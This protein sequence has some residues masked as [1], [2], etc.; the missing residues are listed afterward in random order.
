MVLDFYF[1]CKSPFVQRHDVL[2]PQEM[3]HGEK[4]KRLSASSLEYFLET[5][6]L[7]SATGELLKKYDRDGD[8]SFSKE[9]VVEIIL[10]LRKEMDQNVLLGQT[11]KLLRKLIIATVIFCLVLMSSIFGLAYAVAKLTAK[12]DV[13]AVTG[14]MTT[15]DGSR[16][17]AT[18]S[19]AYKVSTKKHEAT[20]SQCISM[21]ELDDMLGR[22]TSGNIVHLEIKGTGTN[23]T[24]TIVEKLTGSVEYGEDSFC[25]ITTSGMQMCAEPNDDCTPVENDRRSLVTATTKGM[26]FGR[27]AIV[28]T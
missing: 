16:V 15:L 23:G 17:V 26:S 27:G 4:P 5:A 3:P 22:V 9:E 20:G 2:L 13:D 14:V 28:M 11:N 25:F 19:V 12:L 24:Q 18:D 8:G 6:H 1:V 21:E 7:D 10:D